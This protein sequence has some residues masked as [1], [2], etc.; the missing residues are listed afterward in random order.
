MGDIGVALLSVKDSNKE[1]NLN[2]KNVNFETIGKECG[3]CPNNCEIIKIYKDNELIDSY[4]N[5]CDKGLN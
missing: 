1:Y 5:K 3:K 4:G 2:I